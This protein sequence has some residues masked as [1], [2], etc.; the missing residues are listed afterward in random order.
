VCLVVAG[1]NGL[2]T[3]ADGAAAGS[4]GIGAVA[5]GSSAAQVP[6]AVRSMAAIESSSAIAGLV[7]IARHNFGAADLCEKTEVLR[8]PGSVVLQL[9]DVGSAG[10]V[11]FGAAATRA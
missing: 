8:T 7:V 2:I 6:L 9:A 11:G 3:T 4:G 10:L 1:Q 5:T